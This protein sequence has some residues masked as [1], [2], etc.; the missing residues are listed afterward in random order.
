[1]WEKKFFQKKRCRIER[2]DIAFLSEVCHPSDCLPRISASMQQRRMVFRYFCFYDS[3][4]VSWL[5]ASN[6]ISKLR[7]EVG[8]CTELFRFRIYLDKLALREPLLFTTDGVF[9]LC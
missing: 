3:V 9:C 8:L 4:V 1:M 2:P 7:T 5:S 6:P